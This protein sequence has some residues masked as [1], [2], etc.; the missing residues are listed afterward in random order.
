MIFTIRTCFNSKGIFGFLITSCALYR[1]SPSYVFYEK[2]FWKCA[3][4]LK[5]TGEHPTQSAIS[6]KSQSNF[7]EI[8]LR[9]GCFPISLP[10]IFRTTFS[11][12]TSGG[13][14]LSLTLL[15]YV[16][17]WLKIFQKS[18]SVFTLQFFDIY[19]SEISSYS[20]TSKKTDTT[21]LMVCKVRELVSKAPIDIC[22]DLYWSHNI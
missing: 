22:I 7:I 20:V 5:F 13:L 21:V 9:H 18:C 1:S 15:H 16:G 3:A 6:I 8:A 12:N 4:N 19:L 2:E 11:K 14:L 17:K 10:H